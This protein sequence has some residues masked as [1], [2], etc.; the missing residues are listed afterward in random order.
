MLVKFGTESI[1]NIATFEQ[2]TKV[3]AKDCLIKEDCIYFLVDP[4]RVGIAIGRNGTCIKN[5]R[6]IF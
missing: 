3:H 1:R 5:L 4:D 6:K 2:V